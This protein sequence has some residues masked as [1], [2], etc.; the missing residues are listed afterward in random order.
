MEHVV[1]WLAYDYLCSSSL[2]LQLLS[3]GHVPLAKG[4]TTDL[5]A[6]EGVCCDIEAL[7]SFVLP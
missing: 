1:Y 7:Q 5:G 2:W 3:S 6:V 4:T